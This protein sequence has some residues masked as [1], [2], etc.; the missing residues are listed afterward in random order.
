MKFLLLA[1][2]LAALPAPGESGIPG[3]GFITLYAR[4]QQDPPPAILDAIQGELAKVMSPA[5]LQFKWQLL[6]PTRGQV[7]AELVVVSFRGRCDISS[8]TAFRPGPTS[9]ALGWTQITDGVILPF[10]NVDCDG[11]RSLIQTGLLHMEKPFRDAAYGR[12]VGRVLA[13]E[14]YHVFAKTTRHQSH[15]LG[16]A[17]YT[18]QELLEPVLL[19]EECRWA[20]LPIGEDR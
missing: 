4:F 9:G 7:S 20:V 8:L 14:L 2:A 16:K 5:G 11:V 1:V 10:S 15:G 3:N 6:T 17:A 13:H 19:F 18:S 12:A